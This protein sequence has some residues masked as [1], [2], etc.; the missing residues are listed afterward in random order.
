MVVARFYFT[1]PCATRGRPDTPHHP[2]PA[3]SATNVI[4]KG[5]SAGGLAT[6]LNADYVASL[7]PAGV[8][9]V[10]A[11]GA[12]FFL[13]YPGYDG[14][15][16][17]RGNYQW[18]FTAMGINATLSRECLA[19]YSAQAGSPTWKCFGAQYALPFIHTPLFISNSLA[20]RHVP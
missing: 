10:A 4:L 15:F 16:H 11:P 8:A 2:A 18:V 13:D 7:L 12:G 6:F 1:S 19:Y 3:A 17:Y 9:Y 5:C 20:D 14:K